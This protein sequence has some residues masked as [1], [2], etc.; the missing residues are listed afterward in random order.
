MLIAFFASLTSLAV[1]Q[2]I[3]Y[4]T[5]CDKRDNKLYRTVRIGKQTWFAENLK[6]KDP[7]GSSVYPRDQIHENIY[8]RLYTW[9]AALTACPKG[10][11]LPSDD[12][13]KELERTLGMTDFLQNGRGWRKPVEERSLKSSVGWLSAADSADET[14]FS[15]LPGGYCNDEGYYFNE[16][17]FAYFWTSTQTSE[18][19]AWYRVLTYDIH[20]IG[21]F[22]YSKKYRFSIRCVLSVH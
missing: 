16:G 9:E 15:A 14:G 3:Q 12:E 2:N 13:W 22:S 21:K 11:H 10:W 7:K 20:D 19:D 8:G 6:Y 17:F 5:V 4:D 18:T 1:A